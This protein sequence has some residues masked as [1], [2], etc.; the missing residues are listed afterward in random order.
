MPRRTQGL[1]TDGPYGGP[2]GSA[3]DARDNGVKV[4]DIQT[5]TA[6]YNS[7]NVLGAIE[8]TFADNQPSGRIGGKDPN[9][10]YN[11]DQPF[12]FEDGETIENM[13]FYAGDNQ[14]YCNGFEF[15]TN[16]GNHFEGGTKIGMP[17]TVDQLGNGEL[18][19]ASGRD[20]SHG[21]DAVVDSMILYFND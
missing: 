21:A 10:G 19:G 13:T 17:S 4:R 8:F 14:G 9:V 18:A 15:D 7:Y 1:V 12:S 5:W 2:G 11:P 6:N 16:Y 3:Y 20:N